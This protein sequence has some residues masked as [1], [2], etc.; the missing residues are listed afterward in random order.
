MAE[1]IIKRMR[2]ALIILF[3]I[4][5]GV[6]FLIQMQPG[7]P[8]A[9]MVDP[10]LSK[11]MTVEM[12]K[13]LG[14]YDPI[15]IKYFKWILNLLH[16]NMGY[17]IRFGGSVSELI[18]EKIGNTA[19]LGGFSFIIS[20]LC[21]IL[22][23]ITLSNKHGSKVDCLIEG[24]FF[25]LISIPTFF[26]GLIFIKLFSLNYRVFPSSG[27]ISLGGGKAGLAYLWDVIQ[28]MMLPGLVLGIGQFII[29]TKYTKINMLEIMK[30]EYMKVARMK[31]LSKNK[32]VFRHG[33][34]NT[35]LLII[36]VLS[37]QLPFF[38]SGS[39]IT[40]TIFVW[41]GM[42]RLN[43]EAVINKDYPL[44]MGILLFT[45]ILIL[46]T[47]LIADILHVLIDK[48]IEY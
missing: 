1:F 31:G 19:I 4:T 42:G 45:A 12:F 25:I 48:R 47:N 18:L 15:Y 22:M 29:V 34:K 11:E 43:Y 8:Y 37:L 32:V 40:E 10:N 35:I 27:M 24:I 13:K 6:F 5:V 9:Y 21:G 36:T 38:L 17:S 41:P 3:G 16:G 2:T 26:F 28:H 14:Y 7:N 30:K 46:V 20:S 23:G 39:L 44:I 33:L